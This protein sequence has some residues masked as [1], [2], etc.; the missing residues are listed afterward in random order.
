MALSLDIVRFAATDLL[1]EDG[2]PV[3]EV[4]SPHYAGV[5]TEM[6]ACPYADVR[7]GEPMNRTALRQM[8]AVWPALLGSFAALSCPA[9]TTHQAWAV[10][11]TGIALPLVA[12]RPVPRLTSAIFKASLG[13]SQVF[14]A[15]LLSADGVADTPLGS[16]GDGASFFAELDRGRWLVGADQVCAGTAP[17]I[18]QVF[19]ALI[20]RVEAGPLPPDA[21]RV[22]RVAPVAVALHTAHLLAQQAAARRGEREPVTGE[23][24]PWMRAVFALPGRPP[25]HV[26]R[27]FPAGQTPAEVEGYLAEPGEAAFLAALEALG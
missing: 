23:L 10:A 7:A 4:A 5:R 20:G 25:S 11:I 19:D 21:E 26:R 2:R 6:V 14:S 13:L 12:P 9:P 24:H 22:R 8:T 1:D 3:A 16:L 18:G 15:L 27:L 17:M